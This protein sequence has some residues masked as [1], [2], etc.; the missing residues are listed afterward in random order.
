RVRLRQSGVEPPHSQT[1]AFRCKHLITKIVVGSLHKK[2]HAPQTACGTPPT[3]QH[4]RQQRTAKAAD[5]QKARF[6]ATKARAGASFF[7]ECRGI[8]SRW[9][10]NDKGWRHKA[11]A[12]TMPSR[13]RI[14][15]AA[16]DEKHRPLH[17]RG[18]ENVMER[19]G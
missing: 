17:A 19:R 11:A 4:Q 1:A 14:F 15:M 7:G 3:W 13:A 12:I 18:G 6:C 2:P 9:Q 10:I 8:A 16:A 5:S